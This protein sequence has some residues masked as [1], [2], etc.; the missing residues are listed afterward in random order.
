MSVCVSAVW[1]VCLCE[2]SH[3]KI[4]EVLQFDFIALRLLLNNINKSTT[5]NIFLISI[6]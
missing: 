4:N 2:Y 3:A 6:L 5:V 1:L